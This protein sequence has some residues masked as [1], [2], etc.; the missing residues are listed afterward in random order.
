[1]GWTGPRGEGKRAY[2][3]LVT[4]PGQFYPDIVVQ[5]SNKREVIKVEEIPHDRAEDYMKEL[6]E[7]TV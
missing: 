4:I 7:T 1:M 5:G 6:A 2:R 3:A